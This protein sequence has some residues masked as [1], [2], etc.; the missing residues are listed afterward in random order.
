MNAT[1]TLARDKKSSVSRSVSQ[2][3]VINV[4]E[5]DE[6]V[7]LH[8]YAASQTYVKYLNQERNEVESRYSESLHIYIQPGCKVALNVASGVVFLEI[9]SV[10]FKTSPAAFTVW[11]VVIGSLCII[12]S[13]V[14][15]LNRRVSMLAQAHVKTTIDLH[16]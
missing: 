10:P 16:V 3:Q 6:K 5:H 14:L 11:T 15:S 9:H 8:F 12:S 13:A 7:E 1:H 2:Y 4:R